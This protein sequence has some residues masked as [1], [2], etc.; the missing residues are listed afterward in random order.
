MLTKQ[1]D[2]DRYISLTLSVYSF[3]LSLAIASFTFLPH[4]PTALLV[5]SSFLPHYSTAL[6]RLESSLP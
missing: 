1:S 2:T 4:Y 5:L 3:Y 6:E